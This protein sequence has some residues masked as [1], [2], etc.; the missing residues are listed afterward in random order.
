M[1]NA[2]EI[3]DD[4][5]SPVYPMILT[6]KFAPILLYLECQTNAQ[7]RDKRKRWLDGL[8]GLDRKKYPILSH[9]LRLGYFPPEGDALWK[10]QQVAEI[11]YKYSMTIHKDTSDPLVVKLSL[12][13][14]S[15]TALD[16]IIKKEKTSD[17][18][19]CS[20]TKGSDDL[21]IDYRKTYVYPTYPASPD[22][23][24]AT[25]CDLSLLKKEPKVEASGSTTSY[26]AQP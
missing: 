8:V 3:S 14:S 6:D 1:E 23:S 25:Q 17:N 26:K 19:P 20:S 18:T 10:L 21:E 4:A 15:V 12:E 2:I 9:R 11:V 24:N 16:T 7:S 5:E 22:E 13:K